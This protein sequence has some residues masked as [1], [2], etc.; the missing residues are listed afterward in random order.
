M[1]PHPVHRKFRS[2]SGE[3]VECYQLRPIGLAGFSMRLGDLHLTLKTRERSRGILDVTSSWPVFFR[4][5]SSSFVDDS[6]PIGPMHSVCQSWIEQ[7][8]Y[9]GCPCCSIFLPQSAS[10]DRH[11]PENKRGDS[12]GND[13]E[14]WT[15]C[16]GR[17]W[18]DGPYSSRRACSEI[19]LR[20]ALS[21]CRLLSR[22]HTHTHTHS[23]S[24]SLE[25]A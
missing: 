5:F 9:L 7:K 14:C 20:R 11:R 17:R 2:F 16:Y 23:E 15:L 18:S 6:R 13:A 22:T 1:R 8:W 4:L 12:I 25:T 10:E 21:F 3:H 24:I 19:S